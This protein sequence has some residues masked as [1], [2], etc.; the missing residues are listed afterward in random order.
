MGKPKLVTY[1]LQIFM[2]EK[3]GGFPKSWWYP[4]GWMVYFHGKSHQTKFLASGNWDVAVCELENG[5]VEIVDDYPAM[6]W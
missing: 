4:N 3:K 5:P 1:N 6:T 2:G